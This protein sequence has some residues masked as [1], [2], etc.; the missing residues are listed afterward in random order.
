MS[1][2]RASTASLCCSNPVSSMVDDFCSCSCPSICRCKVTNS[3]STCIDHTH[4]ISRITNFGSDPI[5]PTQ[6][7]THPVHEMDSSSS[8]SCFTVVCRKD[9]CCYLLSWARDKI[10][11][12]HLILSAT[13]YLI[14]IGSDMALGYRYY[15]EGQLWFG[16]FTT[17]FILAPW[18]CNWLDF[19]YEDQAV[20]K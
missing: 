2:N 1:A 18:I 16:F 7:H 15:N 9:N 12:P 11:I 10:F 14:D 3:I 13:L 6:D 20:K 4:S 17:I 19:V 8:C 5:Y